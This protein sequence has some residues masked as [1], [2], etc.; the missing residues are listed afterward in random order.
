MISK[1]LSKI[2][3][4]SNGNTEITYTVSE[5]AVPDYTTS[6]NGYEITNQHAPEALSIPVKKVWVDN[7]NAQG[8]RP[9]SV[10]VRLYADGTQVD[11]F[12][13]NAGNNWSHIFNGLPRYTAGHEIEYTVKEDPI[14]HYTTSYSGSSAT[15]LTATNTIEGKV[16]VPVTKKWIG[17]P[18]DSVTIH[19]LA[20]GVEVESAT[21]TAADNWQHTFSNLEFYD[22][23]DGHEYAYTI[24][25]TP[26][27][28]YTT[29]ITGNQDDGF[30]VTNTAPVVPPTTP[31]TTSEPKKPG[32]PYTA[33][34][35]GIASIVGAA[36]LSLSGL[37][38][39]LRRKNS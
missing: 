14:A 18:A 27:S 16:S 31:P 21:L 32:L 13:L 35:S 30:T 9:A 1:S 20:D 11:E 3:I 8:L 19:L 2:E 24:S 6:I 38:I 37:G 29:Q 22:K 36:A 23:T 25:E 4:K 34:A 12:D 26:I 7:E 10:H 15:E 5:D 33:D 17:A 28:G 39:A